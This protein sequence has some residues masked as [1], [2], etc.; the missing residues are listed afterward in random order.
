M[1]RSWVAVSAAVLGLAGAMSSHLAAGRE[2]GSSPA[3]QSRAAQQ[4]A[5]P[6]ART[7]VAPVAQR[8]GVAPA[9]APDRAFVDNVLASR[10]LL[11]GRALERYLRFVERFDA[12]RGPRAEG[13]RAPFLRRR[14]GGEP[15]EPPP[16]D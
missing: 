9:P 5:P 14:F 4:A 3:A 6:A 16:R 1:R 12:S 2:Q 13:G 11:S 15:R 10:G 7:P 8:A